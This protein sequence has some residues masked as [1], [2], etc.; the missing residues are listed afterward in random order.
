MPIPFLFIAIAAGSA[1]FGIGKGVKAGF[2]QNDANKTALQAKNIAD[3]ANKT[4]ENSRENSNNAIIDLGNKKVEILNGAISDFINSFEQIHNIELSASDGLNELHK[5]K[6]D[7]QSLKEL[8]QASAVASS[9]ASGMVSGSIIGAV[10]AFGAYSAVSTFGA[11]STGT[12]I[13]ALSGVA[14]KNATLAF[15][16]GGSLVTGGLGVTGGIT[17]LGGLVAGPALAVM[18]FVVGAKA[19][20]NRDKAYSNLAEARKFCEEVRTLQAVCRGIRMRANMFEYLLVR[21]DTL[22]QPLVYN[23]NE[24]IN[25]TGT[26]YF[27]YSKEQKDTIAAALSLVGAVKSVL[28]TPVLTEDGTLTKESETL[29]ENV[30]GILEAEI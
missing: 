23:I 28:D 5:F 3:T 10:T 30:S 27:K 19:K 25:T 18:G 26:D 16:G 17:V 29:L 22:L 8:K 6:I 14:A 9:L 7:K 11:A 1:A 21:L 2:D 4:A 20:A 15:L 13:A 24:I 12:A